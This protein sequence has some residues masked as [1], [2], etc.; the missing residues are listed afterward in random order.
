MRIE[1]NTNRHNGQITS[2]II[3]SVHEIKT[4]A[5]KNLEKEKLN[6][7]EFTKRNYPYVTNYKNLKYFALKTRSF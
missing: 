4:I 1:T 5:F 6:F 2:L 7:P 3:N